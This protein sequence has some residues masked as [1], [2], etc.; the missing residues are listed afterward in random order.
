[1][2]H[3]IGNRILGIFSP[4][5]SYFLWAIVLTLLLSACG[6]SNPTKPPEDLKDADEIPQDFDFSTTNG[7]EL[8]ISTEDAQG[9]PIKQAYFEV[10]HSFNLTSANPT[11]GVRVLS[12]ATDAEGKFAANIEVPSHVEKLLVYLAYVGLPTSAVVEI[13]ADKKVDVHFA[14]ITG[15]SDLVLRYLLMRV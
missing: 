1:M 5:N 2:Q 10:Y 3:F 13:G 12:G 11:D 4:R 6:I 8:S 14:P 9:L 7:V 15:N